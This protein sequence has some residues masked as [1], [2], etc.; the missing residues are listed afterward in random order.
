MLQELEWSGLG[1]HL[2]GHSC[3]G[4]CVA[5]WGGEWGGHLV[6]LLTYATSHPAVLAHTVLSPTPLSPHLP[7][8]VAG[9]RH[10]N[11]TA[12]KGR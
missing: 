3:I 1:I 4:M 7:S 10:H 2:E 12:F 11:D 9:R 5:G 6:Q 8:F